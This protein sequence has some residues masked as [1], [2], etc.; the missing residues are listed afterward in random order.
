MHLGGGCWR[1]RPEHRPTSA[2][3]V[4]LVK[5]KLNA[6]PLSGHAANVPHT[7]RHQGRADGDERKTPH[8]GIFFTKPTRQ[9]TERQ[10]VAQQRLAAPGRRLHQQLQVR[11]PQDLVVHHPALRR[12]Q[13]PDPGPT[14][15]D[16]VGRA[17]PRHQIE[18][19]VCLVLVLDNRLQGARQLLR[20]LVAHQPRLVAQPNQRDDGCWKR[21]ESGC[22][23]GTAHHVAR[24][25]VAHV[26]HPP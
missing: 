18:Q 4:P 20:R 26:H 7:H 9:E 1:L 10:V 11:R 25:C 17:T 2:A 8:G 14:L 23:D 19:V 5:H 3:V 21:L 13:P 6:Q 22:W 16:G 15:P 24:Q 12:R